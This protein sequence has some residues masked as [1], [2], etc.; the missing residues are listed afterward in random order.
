MTRVAIAQLCS[1]SNLQ[2]NLRTVT[3]LIS[4]ALEQDVAVLFFPEATDFL[5]AN[6]AH[7][8]RL[9]QESPLFVSSLQSRLRELTVE[10]G[11][12]IDVSIGVH[13]PPTEGDVSR[14]DVRVKNVLLYINH[15]GE[16]LQQ[17][18][19]LHLFDVDV[20]NGPILKESN[21][22]QP[23]TR[24]ADILDTPAGRLG[25]A[26]CYD[27]RFPELSLK[28]RSMGAE[29]LCFP[30]AFTVKTGEAHWELLARC[31]AIDTQCFVVMPGQQGEHDV[32]A[33]GPGRD[34]FQG[35]VKRISWGHSMVVGPWGEVLARADPT[36]NAPQLVVADLDLQAQQTVRRNMPLWEQRRRDVFGDFF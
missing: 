31:R 16:I 32:C 24:I 4:R 35:N 28:L 15:K 25:S 23:G 17:Y 20:P 22:V 11:K 34:G 6:A 12:R 13:L 3:G 8:K 2:Q 14:G 5:S 10:H 36:G 30:S 7:S 19:K 9:A 21:S 27:V 18:Q 33:D 29:I 26:L 1:S